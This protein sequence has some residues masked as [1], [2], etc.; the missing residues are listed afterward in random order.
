MSYLSGDEGDIKLT[1]KLTKIGKSSASDIVVRGFMMGKTAA[2]ISKKPQGYSLSYVEGITKPKVNGAVVKESVN[3][4]EFD[5]IEI[6]SV[7]M[8]FVMEK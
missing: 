4:K 3:L 7:K 5:I 1:K 6:G 8:Q 2:T